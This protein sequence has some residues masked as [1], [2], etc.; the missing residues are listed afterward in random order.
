MGD[1]CIVFPCEMA[2]NEQIMKSRFYNV[3]I[4]GS[5]GPDFGGS[6]SFRDVGIS[7]NMPYP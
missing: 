5:G 3:S 6:Y 1:L 4:P 7:G 2:E